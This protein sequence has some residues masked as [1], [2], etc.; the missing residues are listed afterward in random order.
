MTYTLEQ[1]VADK[2]LRKSI[3]EGIFSF[4]DELGDF[5]A[6]DFENESMRQNHITAFEVLYSLGGDAL[7]EKLLSEGNT[8]L[9][10]D[11]KAAKVG[12]KEIAGAKG[13]YLKTNASAFA[14][15][16]SILFGLSGLENTDRFTFNVEEESSVYTIVAKETE[17]YA[18][19]LFYEYDD[20]YQIIEKDD[21]S[22]V[23]VFTEDGNQVSFVTKG[24]YET[25]EFNSFAT[26]EPICIQSNEYNEETD[27]YELIDKPIAYRYKLQGNDKWGF[28]G[29]AYNQVIPPMF[30]DILLVSSEAG[31]MVVALQKCDFY[32]K[33]AA[34]KMYVG[35]RDRAAAFDDVV[36]INTK[37]V[38]VIG[39]NSIPN[40]KSYINKLVNYN[41]N[42]EIVFY[43][44]SGDR[45]N[46]FVFIKDEAPTGNFV[47][48]PEEAVC[49]RVQLVQ[50]VLKGDNTANTLPLAANSFIAVEDCEKL[51]LS[52]ERSYH[53]I[54]RV[55][56]DY[57]IV[58][59]EGFLGIAKMC[60]TQTKRFE[61]ESNVLKLDEM[62]VPYAFTGIYQ[63]NLLD[64]L[65]V[66]RFGKKGVFQIRIK[67]YVI[68][69]DYDEISF[70]SWNKYRVKK[71][72]FSGVID[73]TGGICNWIET[74]HREE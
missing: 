36:I 30:D 69:C 6:V 48:H 22:Y 9:T 39:E 66:D 35:E 2:E 73:I 28:L 65:I 18:T 43:S 53:T 27:E 25:V 1:L 63:T 17:Q 71:A 64:N 41:E 59:R 42:R 21:G 31:S 72:D 8:C 11:P 56:E 51:Y 60:R 55:Y 44:W 20:V 4:S 3:V 38:C 58:E 70:V 46:G 67:K 19:G 45:Q 12:V 24:F 26:L 57:Y 74:L 33:T 47:T 62:I 14:A 40:E 37:Y 13:W 32:S 10:N 23:V 16:S 68:P 54:K 61:K 29:A 34:Y 52:E 5:F 7:F 50:D 49:N 15:F